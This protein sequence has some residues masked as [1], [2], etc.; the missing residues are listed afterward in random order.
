MK[1]GQLTL[2]SDGILAGFLEHHAARKE[3]ALKSLPTNSGPSHEIL[4]SGRNT[5]PPSHAWPTAG[6][7]LKAR[8]SLN[9]GATTLY[10]SLQPIGDGGYAIHWDRPRATDQSRARIPE[11]AR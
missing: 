7:I 1:I 10:L 4:V 6:G 9:N 11:R 2:R 3:L 5:H 8:L